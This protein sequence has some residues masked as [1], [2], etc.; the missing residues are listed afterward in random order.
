M[1]S[2]QYK[3]EYR[4]GASTSHADCPSRL[5]LPDTPRK[6]PVPQE[7]VIAL[8][9]IDESPITSDQIEKWTALDQIIS[10]VRHLV[11]HGWSN[12]APGELDAYCQRKDELSVQQGVLFWGARVIVPPKGRD[13]LLD[14]LHKTHPG[15]GKMKALAGCYMWW[16][17]LDME[18]ERYVKDCSVSAAR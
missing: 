6:V 14:E 11:E 10:Q 9:T 15:I 3:L 17:G 4:P 2:Y 8:S 12:Q 18:I 13:Y 7:V 5:P 16:S 1:N